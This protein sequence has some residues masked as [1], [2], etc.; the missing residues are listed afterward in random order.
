MYKNITSFGFYREMADL[1][2]SVEG[3]EKLF[4]FLENREKEMGQLIE[5][6]PISFN[7]DFTEYESLYDF[8]MS[9]KYTKDDYEN[10]EEIANDCV[11]VIDLENGGFILEGFNGK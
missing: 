5:F 3:A 1:G 9:E 4:E 11:S 2:F 7:V 10:L 8:L 6:D